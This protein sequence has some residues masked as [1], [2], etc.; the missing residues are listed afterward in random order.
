M[1]LYLTHW[2]VSSLPAMRDVFIL[3]A[4]WK[5]TL[6]VR[7]W[8][9]NMWQ[10]EPRCFPPSTGTGKVVLQKKQGEA[11]GDVLAVNRRRWADATCMEPWEAATPLCSLCPPWLLHSCMQKSQTFLKLPNPQKSTVT[12]QTQQLLLRISQGSSN[13]PFIF[14]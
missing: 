10:Y 7:V 14:F 12:V 8:K 2:E 11:G 4:P 1:S 6:S 13:P 5:R 9:E 3:S